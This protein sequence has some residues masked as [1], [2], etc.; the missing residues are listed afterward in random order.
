MQFFYNLAG[1]VDELDNEGRDLASV[2]EARLHAVK[3]VGEFLSEWPEAV[4]KG[5]TFRVEVTNS[6]NRTVFTIIVQ[7]VNAGGHSEE[8]GSLEAEGWQ[9][10]V[11]A[12]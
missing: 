9:K 10:L 12:G 1:A 2:Q 6:A 8:A 11:C 4:W 3:F 5:E 7:G